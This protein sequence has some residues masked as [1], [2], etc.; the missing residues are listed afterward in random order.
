MFIY[1]IIFLAIIAIWRYAK[2]LMKTTMLKNYK[3]ILS[4]N[5]TSPIPNKN[6][7]KYDKVP[8]SLDAIVIG[9]GIGGL[10]TAGFLSRCGRKVLVL[11]QHDIAGGSTHSFEDHGF[12]FDTG[13]HYVGNMSKRKKILDLICLDKIEWD[14]MGSESDFVYDEIYL[15]DEYYRFRAGKENF[16]N[17]LIK[18]FPDEADAIRSYIELVE[19]VSKKDLFFHLKILKP[20][21][22][23]NIIAK[24][25]CQEFYR[26]IDETTYDVIKRFTKN[27]KLIAVL[28]GQFGDI[29]KPPKESNFFMHASIVNH[30]LEGGW[31]PRGGS[32]EIA[33]RLV[34]RSHN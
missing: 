12:E 16:I 18:K 22:L 26:Y 29:G 15:E 5:K 28:C 19:K 4:T 7:Y 1:L 13:I 21:F 2:I 30:Y 9:S 24:Y 11:E 33:N 10:S 32:S 27:E 31:Y 23:A 14:K 25:F 6:L 3:H 34:P 17:D 20:K 8:Q